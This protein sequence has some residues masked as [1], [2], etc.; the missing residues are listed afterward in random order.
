MAKTTILSALVA[1]AVLLG[2]GQSVAAGEAVSQPMQ[3]TPFASG[4]AGYFHADGLRHQPNEYFPAVSF[5]VMAGEH[6]GAELYWGW[7]NSSRN[8]NPP[9]MRDVRMHLAQINGLYRF[10]VSDVLRPY[11]LAGIG[12]LHAKPNGVISALN[13][14][15]DET[16]V[17]FNVTA[18]GGVML[19]FSPLVAT[20]F[21]VRDVFTTP[22]R[23]NDVIMNAGVSL[24]MPS[25]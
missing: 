21:E 7:I 3:F 11:L 25:A 4:F 6:V 23:A 14:S 5:G 20:R 15:G 24:F 16:H 2:V 22:T 9:A 1:S 10:T 17:Q 12:M 8:D 18:G 19:Q 13:P